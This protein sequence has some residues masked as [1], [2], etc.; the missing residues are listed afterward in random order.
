MQTFSTTPDM[1]NA[2]VGI[3]IQERL[4]ACHFWYAFLWKGVY[5]KMKNLDY[6]LYAVTTPCDSLLQ[7]VEAAIGGGIT[8][9]QIREKNCATEVRVRH[10][11][12]LLALCRKYRIPCVINDDVNAAKILGADGVHVGQSDMSIRVARKILGDKVFIGTSVHNVEEARQA[13]ADGADYIGCGAVFGSKTKADASFLS[14]QMLHRICCEIEIPVVAIGGIGLKN[15]HMLKNSGI[16]GIAVVSAIFGQ[17]DV[18]QSTREL[19][20]IVD[21]IVK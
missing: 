14:L 21:K 3:F 4:R 9:L 12:P 7:Q 1:G 8:M 6:R 20:K 17:S 19:R 5:I 13:Q 16:N 11:Q 2:N 10:A 18:L 15:V